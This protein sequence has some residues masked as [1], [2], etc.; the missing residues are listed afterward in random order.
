M[1]RMPQKII[2]FC[3]FVTKLAAVV[4]FLSIVLINSANLISRWIF[5]HSFEWVLEISL[6]LIVYSVM[7]VVPVLYHD[8]A[9]IRMHLLEEMIG[10]HSAKHVN[11][12]AECLVFTFMLFLLYH[13]LSLSLGQINTLSRGLGIPRFYVTIPL[14]IGA[15]FSL[16]IGFDII[17]QHIDKYIYDDREHET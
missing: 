13:G 9:F 14:S 12:L 6:I 17:L 7:L 8:G 2:K 4:T 15:A 1:I 5:F 11:L 3:Y 16:P 10:K